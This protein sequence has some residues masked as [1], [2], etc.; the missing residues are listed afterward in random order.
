MAKPAAD[1]QWN[2]VPV[3]A[4]PIHKPLPDLDSLTNSVWMAVEK[5]LRKYGK[6]GRLHDNSVPTR[7]MVRA[8]LVTAMPEA[9][10][11]RK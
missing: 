7:A 11:G 1:V 2:P 6:A 4:M 10:D 8:L 9:F 5:E 3:D